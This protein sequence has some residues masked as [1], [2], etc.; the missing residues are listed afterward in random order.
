[1]SKIVFDSSAVLALLNNE[2][3]SEV[4]RANLAEAAMS[5]VN[6]AEVFTRLARGGESAETI[7][8][9]VRLL[10]IDVF[11]FDA[12]LAEDAG[13]LV[14]NTGKAGLSL[15]DRAC[16][17]LAARENLPVLTADRAWKGVDVG[18]P[19]QFIR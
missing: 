16:L 1:M 14:V 13:M 4:V 2:P 6:T 8:N 17:A 11:E 12:A 3:G 18:V 9:S 10:N 7:R 15:G 5:A 19:I